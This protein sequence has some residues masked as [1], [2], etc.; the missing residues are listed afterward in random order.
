MPSRKSSCVGPVPSD[1]PVSL[2]AQS[3]VTSRLDSP[4]CQS[5]APYLRLANLHSVP[6][7]YIARKIDG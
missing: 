6:P 5:G 7:A 3:L 1:A 4:E 2:K